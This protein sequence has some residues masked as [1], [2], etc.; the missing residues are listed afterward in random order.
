MLGDLQTAE[1]RLDLISPQK[2]GNDASFSVIRS[3]GAPSGRRRFFIGVDAVVRRKGIRR[4]DF[5]IL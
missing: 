2:H 1:T 3:S 5:A 4:T